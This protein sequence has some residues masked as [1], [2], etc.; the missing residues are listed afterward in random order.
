MEFLNNPSEKN[1]MF[2][3]NT[4]SDLRTCNDVIENLLDTGFG[5]TFRQND[6]DSLGLYNCTATLTYE[7]R[8]S[9]FL[10]E[11]VN[12]QVISSLRSHGIEI[13]Q[14]CGV[15]NITCCSNDTILAPIASQSKES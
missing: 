11:N 6:E 14:E 4:N 5:G 2:F 3:P 15:F 9:V 10:L 8:V 7:C 1:A 13:P 12:A